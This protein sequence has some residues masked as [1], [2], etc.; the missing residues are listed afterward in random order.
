MSDIQEVEVALEKTY[1]LVIRVVNFQNKP[2][3]DVNVKVFRF[4]KNR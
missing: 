3:K 4:K 2:I 1:M